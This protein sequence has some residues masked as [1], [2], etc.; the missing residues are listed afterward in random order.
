M[1]QQIVAV[2]SRDLASTHIVS[3]HPSY[4]TD[5]HAAVLYGEV[6]V[7]ISITTAFMQEAELK[8]DTCTVVARTSGNCC[9]H[10]YQCNGM[11]MRMGG[12]GQG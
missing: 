7:E 3:V 9:C 12:V 8:L 5:I 2:V 11:G 4:E 6:T 10:R 1:T